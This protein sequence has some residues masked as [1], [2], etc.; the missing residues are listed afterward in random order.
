MYDFNRANWGAFRGTSDGSEEA[1]RAV[2]PLRL[3]WPDSME[4]SRAESCLC[5]LK[6]KAVEACADRGAGQVL[7]V[8][9]RAPTLMLSH[10]KH[11]QLVVIVI[12]HRF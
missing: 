2:Y 4:T 3:I 11:P 12:L 8:P 5:S 7:Q 10:T 6:E 1:R 9:T